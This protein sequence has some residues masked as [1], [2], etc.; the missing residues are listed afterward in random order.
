LCTNARGVRVE[1]AEA[2]GL[3]LDPQMKATVLPPRPTPH[4]TA[5][6]RRRPAARVAERIVVDHRI[7]AKRYQDPATNFVTRWT[8]PRGRSRYVTSG[9]NIHASVF[10]RMTLVAEYRPGNLPGS[11]QRVP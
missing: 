3:I 8:I 9:A 10:E 1:K 2:G 4:S 11:Y 7:P 6:F 5:P